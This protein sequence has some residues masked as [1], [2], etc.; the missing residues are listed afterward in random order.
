MD[1]IEEIF[2]NN[3]QWVTEKLAIDAD[4]FENLVKDKTPNFYTL[5][6]ATAVLL[7]KN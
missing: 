5:A 3:R 1:K 6:A 7:P 2:A 4:Y